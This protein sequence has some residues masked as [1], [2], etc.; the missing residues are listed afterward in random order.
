MV[1]PQREMHGAAAPD[2]G[3]EQ[4]RTGRAHGLTVGAADCE[5]EGHLVC[6]ECERD[7]IAR[8]PRGQ[9]LGPRPQ[10]RAAVRTGAR[11]PPA[12]AVAA[13]VAREERRRRAATWLGSGLGLGLG[14]GVGLG[15]GLEL[16]LELGLG[17]GLG[18]GSG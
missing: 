13:G 16:G 4:Q 9:T 18:L 7:R 8:A 1:P 12:R 14:L 15:L 11:P 6:V 3:A 17:L 10:L 5:T 2:L